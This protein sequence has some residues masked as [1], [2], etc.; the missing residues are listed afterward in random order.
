MKLNYNSLVDKNPD[1][2]KIQ[3]KTLQKISG[4]RLPSE[5]ETFPDPYPKIVELSI[6]TKPQIETITNK[7]IIPQTI[8]FLP[9]FL[10]SSFPP[11]HMYV[12]KPQIKPNTAKDITNGTNIEIKFINLAI[13]S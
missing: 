2:F 4:G 7:A 12:T 1:D 13:K 8:N 3:T 9:S 10:F 6:P 5:E 11:L